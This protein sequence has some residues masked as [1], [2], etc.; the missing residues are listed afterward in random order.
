MPQSLGDKTIAD[1]GDQWTVYTDNSGYYGSP[2]LL[3]DVFGPMLPLDSLKGIAIA[4]V[5]AGTGRFSLIFAAA[6]AEKVI[7]V[8]PSAAFD[9]LVRN[10]ESVRSRVECVRVPVERFIPPAP[11]DFAFSYGVLHHIPDPEQ[12]VAAMHRALR[13]GGRIGI[14]LYGYEGNAA[15]VALLHAVALVT[16]RLPHRLLAAVVGLAYLPILI[17]MWACR[18]LPLP[19]RGYFVEVFAKLTADKRRLTLYDQL[20]PAYAKY[21]R[22]AEVRALL[23]RAGFADIQLFHRHGYSWTALAT[24]H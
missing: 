15:Y 6:G 9:V 13:P 19:L 24:K 22:Q 16:R 5:G 23:E 20:N 4:D 12:A 8:E 2:A 21:Y 3:Q 18:V 7:A 11:I 17:Y 1:F 14:W 10:T